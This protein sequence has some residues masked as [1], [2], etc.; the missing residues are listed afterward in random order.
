M[1]AGSHDAQPRSPFPTADSTTV[2]ATVAW[3]FVFL[4]PTAIAAALSVAGATDGRDAALWV[5]TLG[6]W[7]FT[8]T[9]GLAA[10][11]R[12]GALWWVVPLAVSFLAA[13]LALGLLFL[14][15]TAAHGMRNRAMSDTRSR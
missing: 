14:L 11:P 8:L 3:W 10:A 6:V 15:D 1:A 9:L 12:Q 5:F 7:A 13:G 2:R 4:G